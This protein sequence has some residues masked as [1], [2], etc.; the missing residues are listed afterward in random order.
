VVA[1]VAW[2]GHRKGD[3]R[4]EANRERQQQH[5]RRLAEVRFA[6]LHREQRRHQEYD[7]VI[8][9][10]RRV[11]ELTEQGRVPRSSPENGRLH[12]EKRALPPNHCRV[13]ERRVPSRANEQRQLSV[14]EQQR[15]QRSPAPNPGRH[16]SKPGRRG[17]REQHHEVHD[18]SAFRDARGAEQQDD[19]AHDQIDAQQGPRPY[20]DDVA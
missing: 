7:R 16:D 3:E 4:D 5:E 12:A 18:Q 2:P 9:D 1:T 10:V 11:Q 15:H 8:A 20:C 17:D 13:E 19:R 6:L 14:E